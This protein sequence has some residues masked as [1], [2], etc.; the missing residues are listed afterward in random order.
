M[1]RPRAR[2]SGSRPG[3]R[4]DGFICSVGSGG[5]L[6]GV[7]EALRSRNPDVKIGLADPEGAALYNYYANGELKSS[8][9]SITEGIGQGRITANLEGL[10]IDNP[11]QISGCRG[12][13]LHLRPART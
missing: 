6:A 13:A 8:G 3:G 11:Y 4:I 12:P 10:K 1:S 5:T 9:N 7:A 2:K